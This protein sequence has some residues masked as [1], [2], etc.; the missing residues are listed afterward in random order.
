MKIF[1]NEPMTKVLEK[2]LKEFLKKSLLELQ[3]LPLEEHQEKSLKDFPKERLKQ[4][5]VFEGAPAKFHNGILEE[6]MELLDKSLK[7]FEKKSL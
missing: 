1:P 3:E 4:K 7:G 6:M 2:S 5:G